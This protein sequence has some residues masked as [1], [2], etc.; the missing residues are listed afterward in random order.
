MLPTLL[1]VSNELG[2]WTEGVRYELEGWY[3]ERAG[4]VKRLA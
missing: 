3:R 2:G 4:S 1:L